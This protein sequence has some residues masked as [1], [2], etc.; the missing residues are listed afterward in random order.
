[1][2]GPERIHHGG[3]AHVGADGVPLAQSLEIAARQRVEVH[4]RR[5]NP[6][7][8]SPSSDAKGFRIF[9][10]WNGASL[11]LKGAGA[12]D[13]FSR[14]LVSSREVGRCTWDQVGYVHVIYYI[15]ISITY[16]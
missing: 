3:V 13:G 11:G 5:R 8:F 2:E 15:Y 9:E 10:R 7:R 4:G 1:L 6:C 12:R 14:C 16:Y